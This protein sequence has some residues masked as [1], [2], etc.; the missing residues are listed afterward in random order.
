MVW[1]H[2]AA[3]IA[4]KRAC[5]CVAVWV[6]ARQAVLQGLLSAAV[7]VWGGGGGVWGMC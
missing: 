5:M 6:P 2:V 3:L 1:Q 4:G 7:C